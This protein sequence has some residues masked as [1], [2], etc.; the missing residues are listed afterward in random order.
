MKDLR[1]VKIIFG[2]EIIRDMATKTLKISQLVYIRDLLKEENLTDHNTSTILIKTGLA[3]EIN[4]SGNYG[5][6]DFGI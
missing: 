4:E 6:V 5:K 2:W 1:E 3:I